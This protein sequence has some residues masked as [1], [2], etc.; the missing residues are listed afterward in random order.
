MHISTVY[1]CILTLITDFSL[2]VT[3]GRN[4]TLAAGFSLTLARDILQRL[5]VGAGEPD[6]YRPDLEEILRGFL[7]EVL[8]ELIVGIKDV[9]R[10]LFAEC[11][12]DYCILYNNARVI[13]VKPSEQQAFDKSFKEI[14]FLNVYCRIN[15]GDEM[16]GTL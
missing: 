2:V 14:L 11:K 12:S 15:H 13:A 3:L 4:M 16:S 10:N 6:E 1:N 8:D 7:C 5:Y 9:F